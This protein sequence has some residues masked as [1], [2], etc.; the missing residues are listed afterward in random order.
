MVYASGPAAAVASSS[1]I[2]S[3]VADGSVRVILYDATGN[4][5]VVD[6]NHKLVVSPDAGSGNTI[7]PVDA[8]TNAKTQWFYPTPP[9]WSV[10]NGITWD[11]HYSISSAG[12]GL[13]V[14]QT[15]QP[16]SIPYSATVTNG[17]GLITVAAVAGQQHRITHL[18]FSA[19]GTL[20]GVVT[21]TVDDGATVIWQADITA[22]GFYEASL[23]AGGLIGTTNT[24][25]T[26]NSTTGGATGTV[27][28]NA[29]IL[30]A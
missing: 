22:D 28:L 15:M 4:P 25:M 24:A 23:P 1:A 30:T 10:F 5:V 21:V 18:S 16:S 27:K 19:S 14:A 3:P 2:T 7:N 13:G 29:A 20:S 26:I 11:R 9:Y 12:A 6:A 8:S 17:A